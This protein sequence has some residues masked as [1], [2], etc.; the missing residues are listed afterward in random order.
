MRSHGNPEIVGGLERDMVLLLVLE[1]DDV[2]L[3]E[4]LAHCDDE[5]LVRH[6]WVE[7]EEADLLVEEKLDLHHVHI[8]PLRGLKR[9]QS[10]DLVHH[11][12][13]VLVEALDLLLGLEAQLLLCGHRFLQRLAQLLLGLKLTNE[14]LALLS[15]ALEVAEDV[16]ARLALCV[17]LLR[18]RGLVLALL[19]DSL[20]QLLD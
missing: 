1:L 2:R 16:Q 4:N 3:D 17:E 14:V 15:L 5:L 8:L 18:Q 19:L 7:F 13:H 9:L 6:V 11:L 20:A 12:L 10:V